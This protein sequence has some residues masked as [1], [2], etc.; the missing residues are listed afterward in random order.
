ME[1]KEM[2]DRMVVLLKAIEKKKN[3][4]TKIMTDLEAMCLEAL[5]LQKKIDDNVDESKG[6]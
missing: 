1:L 6:E 4:A 5:S 3:E 2:N